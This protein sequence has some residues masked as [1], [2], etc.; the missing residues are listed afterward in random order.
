MCVLICNL[1]ILQIM[2]KFS[3][4]SICM[5]FMVLILSLLLVNCK[6]RYYDY[7]K[8]PAIAAGYKEGSLVIIKLLIYPDSIYYYSNSNLGRLGRW[9]N[10]GDTLELIQNGQIQARLLDFKPIEINNQTYN[11]LNS[12]PIIEFDSPKVTNFPI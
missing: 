1:N 11:Y 5:S 4:H 10:K 7:H 9:T 6:D 8:K 3:N 2:V 12:L